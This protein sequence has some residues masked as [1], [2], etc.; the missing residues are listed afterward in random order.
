MN[1]IIGYNGLTTIGENP[2]RGRIKA[3]E[4]A[5]PPYSVIRYNQWSFLREETYWVATRGITDGYAGYYCDF[6][7][8]YAT[9]NHFSLGCQC[10]H[11][12]HGGE[13]EEGHNIKAIVTLDS[14]VQIQQCDGTNSLSNPHIITK[15]DEE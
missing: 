3:T 14:N 8:Y 5:F 7:I 6:G 1:H 9:A 15:Y 12:G 2:N 10:P 4:S 11:S 13:E